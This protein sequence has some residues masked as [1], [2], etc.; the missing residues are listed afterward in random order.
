MR[1]RWWRTRCWRWQVP[2]QRALG[3]STSKEYSTFTHRGLGIPVARSERPTP[4]PSIF[5]IPMRASSVVAFPTALRRVWACA[6][7]ASGA[8]EGGL[9]NSEACYDD[10]ELRAPFLLLS[11]DMSAEPLRRKHRRVS[12]RVEFGT[13]AV[14]GSFS[15]DFPLRPA[16]AKEEASISRPSRFPASATTN[17]L[18]AGPVQRPDGGW[19]SGVVSLDN[20]HVEA[21]PEPTTLA[22]SQPRPRS[23]RL[24]AQGTKA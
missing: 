11:F 17:Q 14:G 20:L 2:S 3:S 9:P 15:Y 19:R 24:Q 18:F 4:P 16:T 7:L 23:L 1:S 8:R 5:V 22:L 6:W 13:L 21:V 12:L 10:R